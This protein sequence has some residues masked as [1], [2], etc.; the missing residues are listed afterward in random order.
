MLNHDEAANLY[1]QAGLFI[2]LV[3]NREPAWVI[4]PEILEALPSQI[5]FA[6]CGSY[7]ADTLRDVLEHLGPEHI[8]EYH[9]F[10]PDEKNFQQLDALSERCLLIC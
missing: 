6:D 7:D 4:P 10:E 9:A 3:F 1:G 8:K 5:T 2:V